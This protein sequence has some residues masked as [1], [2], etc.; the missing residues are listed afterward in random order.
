VEKKEGY[1]LLSGNRTTIT[2]DEVYD[3]IAKVIDEL[4]TEI[5]NYGKK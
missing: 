3:K 1:Y 2:N 5:G 4:R